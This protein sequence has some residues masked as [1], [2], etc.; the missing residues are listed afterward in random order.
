MVEVNIKSGLQLT[1]PTMGIKIYVD[2]WSQY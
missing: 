2:G 1:H